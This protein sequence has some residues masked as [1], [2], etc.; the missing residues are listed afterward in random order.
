MASDASCE[1]YR[2]RWIV[3]VDAP[4]REGGTVAVRGAQ[5]VAVNENLPGQSAVDLGDVAVLPGLINAHT[6]LEFSPLQEPLGRPGMAFPDWI[7]TVVAHRRTVDAERPSE[8]DPAADVLWGL[9][10]SLMQG[11]TAVGDIVTAD[12]PAGVWHRATVR[13]IAFR[14]LRGLREDRYAAQLVAARQH[15]HQTAS[16]PAVE[17]GLSPHAPYTVSR[18]LMVEI[19]RLARQARCP[20]ALHLAESPEELELLATG[21]GPFRTLLERFDAWDAAAFAQPSR[22]RDYLEILA[23]APRSLVIHG[24]YLGPDDWTLLAGHANSMAVVFCPHTHRYFAHPRY[25]LAAMLRHGVRVVIGTDSRASNPDGSLW[26][27]LQTA[28][29]AHADVP[30]AQILRMGTLDAAAA[31]GWDREVG[32]LQAGKRADLLVV[33]APP[34]VRRPADLLL[35]PDAQV[36]R[37]MQGGRWVDVQR[38]QE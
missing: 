6:H 15:L 24:N 28:A 8:A 38:R 2:A 20:V 30:P 19:C 36:V 18:P 14:E 3:P 23:A 5:L 27:E 12:L 22:P 33:Q 35:A 13:C 29:R 34:T 10:Q 16:A 25:P 7:A 11:V 31:L 4:P 1:V 21:G 32:S 26:R 17:G 37:V 9:E